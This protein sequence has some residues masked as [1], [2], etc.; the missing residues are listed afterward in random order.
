VKKFLSSSLVLFIVACSACAQHSFSGLVLD[1]TANKYQNSVSIGM[2]KINEYRDSVVVNTH[3]SFQVCPFFL[4]WTYSDPYNNNSENVSTLSLYNW[5]WIAVFGIVAIGYQQDEAHLHPWFDY[6]V[7]GP[8]FLINS[9][10]NYIFL[11]TE[12]GKTNFIW[13][14]IF[15]KSKLDYFE[16]RQNKWLRY[17]PGFGIELV[18]MV[19]LKGGSDIGLALDAG[20]DKPL[21]Y[22]HGKWQSNDFTPMMSIKILFL[23]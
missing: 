18:D 11:S 10:H 7:F 9:Q 5:G 8:S 2:K 16:Q 17:K 12:T 13:A 22:V 15:G 19:K 6:V 1:V 20:F 23:P 3:Y 4:D 21:D 14:S